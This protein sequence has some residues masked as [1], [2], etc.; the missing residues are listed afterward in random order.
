MK[1][2]YV[3]SAWMKEN[4]VRSAIVMSLR[5]LLKRKQLL[6]GVPDF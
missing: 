1:E 3:H 2:N 5:G 4:G 6:Y